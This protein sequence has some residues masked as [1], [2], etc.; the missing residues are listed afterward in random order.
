M[1][2]K[3]L[4]LTLLGAALLVWAAVFTYPEKDLHLVFCDV[5][6]GDG[7]LVIHDSTQ[8][9][10]DG[11]PGSKVLSCLS[12]HLPFW[13]KTIEMVISTHPDSDHL[14]G[15]VSVIERYNVKQFVSNSLVIDTA[16]FQ[17]AR[18]EILAKKIPVYSPKAG[19]KLKVGQF[20]LEV[21]W[22]E[23]KQGSE[24]VWTSSEDP[25]VLGIEVFPGKTNESSVVTRLS[26]G[27]FDVLL[28]GDVEA[29][30]EEMIEDKIG[31]VEVLKVAHHGSKYS[32]SQD[33]LEKISPELA[34]ISVG[35]NPYG[36][37]TKEVI[38]RLANLA[39]KV[40]R[41]DLDG[42]VEV[43]SDGKTWYTTNTKQ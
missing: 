41:T 22:P 40:L 24:L 12:K 13:D 6:Q 37:P 23:E 33:F 3:Y 25:Q 2:I 14:A 30:Q 11:G 35:S 4:I 5:G 28:P 21:F 42:E 18:E 36:H 8:V 38:E 26:Y 15:L 19:D 7:I 39:I 29:S 10:I 31:D 1:K 16:I 20:V 9:L 17:A 34:I 32:S 27:E 43:V